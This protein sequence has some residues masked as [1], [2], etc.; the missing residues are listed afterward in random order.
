MKHLV[1]KRFSDQPYHNKATIILSK[2]T[3]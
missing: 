2:R 3:V 1:I